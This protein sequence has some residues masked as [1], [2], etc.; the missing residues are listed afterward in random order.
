METIK[1]VKSI[2]KEPYLDTDIVELTIFFEGK[3]KD[4]V[5]SMMD[6]PDNEMY[7][8]YLKED[9]K[10]GCIRWVTVVNPIAM[11]ESDNPIT[12][13]IEIDT[14]DKVISFLDYVKQVI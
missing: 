7:D 2:I 11:V 3:Q 10:D 5:V 13:D 14:G 12:P 4:S 9:R 1:K 6:I 8:V